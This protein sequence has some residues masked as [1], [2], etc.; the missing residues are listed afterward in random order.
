[1]KDKNFDPNMLK[2]VA[3][4]MSQAF[5]ES[6]ANKARDQK[7]VNELTAKVDSAATVT[8]DS[9]GHHIFENGLVLKRFSAVSSPTGQ[10]VVVPVEVFKCA[11]CSHVNEEFLPS[12]AISDIKKFDMNGLPTY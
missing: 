7:M 3:G 12:Y 2:Q 9:C 11:K 10:E 5:T 1:M 4:A 8:C 6:S